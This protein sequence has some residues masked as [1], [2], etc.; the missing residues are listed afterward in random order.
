MRRWLLG[1]AAVTAVSVACGTSE[2]DVASGEAAATDGEIKKLFDVNDLSILFPLSSAI[3]VSESNIWSQSNFQEVTAAAKSLG[4]KNDS[5]TKSLESMD[6]WRVVSMRFDPCAPGLA[7]IENGQAAKFGIKDCLVEMRLIAQPVSGSNTTDNAAHLVFD[8][9]APIPFDKLAGEAKREGSLLNEM[10]TDLGDIRDLSGNTAGKP[11]GVHPGLKANPKKTDPNIGGGKTLEN[12]VKAF[13]TKG[14]EKAAG[15]RI[16]FMG[17]K[18]AGAE[19]WTFFAGSV[20]GGTWKQSPQLPVHGQSSQDLDFIS[21]N[22]PVNP[23]TTN[24]GVSTSA[25]FKIE[26]PS[27]SDIEAAFK[28]ENVSMANFFTADCVSCHT[29]SSRILNVEVFAN[30]GDAQG[31]PVG[32][33]AGDLKGWTEPPANITGYIEKA[34]QQDDTWNVRNFGYFGAKPTVSGRA[35]TETVEIVD[36]LNTN[37][38]PQSGTKLHGPG[39]SC[40]DKAQATWV[41]LREGKSNCFTKNNCTMA[42]ADPTKP[43]VQ[44]SVPEPPPTPEVQPIP[45]ATPSNDPCSPNHT[46][47]GTATEVVENDGNAR[48][49]TLKGNNFHC[50]QRGTGGFFVTPDFDRID[51]GF[52]CNPGTQECTVRVKSPTLHLEGEEAKRFQRFFTAPDRKY[53]S[54]HDGKLEGSRLSIKCSSPTSCDIAVK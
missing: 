29:S 45:P 1:L 54:L 4:L 38:V 10:L 48:I 30:P 11:L 42:K 52:N 53:D 3:K 13:I 47:A 15:R 6:S 49:V 25:L 5:S 37:T 16:A 41:C 31:K 12:L 20:Q 26:K 27:Q 32:E 36:W 17:L 9:G 33:R 2:D 23:A 35:L 43:E 7:A 50:F 21:G 19:P 39:L 28:V 44:P 46:K 51:F 18:N 34:L 8:L 40:G 22:G 24:G 14:V